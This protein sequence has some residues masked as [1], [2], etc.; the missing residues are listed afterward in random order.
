LKK[1]AM[2]DYVGV[3]YYQPLVAGGRV[4]ILIL[5]ATGRQYYYVEAS[6]DE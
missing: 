4:R 5:V 2:G 3:E 1:I 6:F